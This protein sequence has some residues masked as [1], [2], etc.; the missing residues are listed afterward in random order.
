MRRSPTV[1]LPAEV[2]ERIGP[3]YGYVLVDPR[4][5]SIFYVGKGTGGRLLAHGDEALLRIGSGGQS[6]KVAR[7]RDGGCTGW[8]RYPGAD[9]SE[10]GPFNGRMMA[11]A[12]SSGVA[13]SAS[14]R[15]M[16]SLSSSSL[17]W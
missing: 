6:S 14:S 11:L 16:G 15:T 3:Y 9:Y 12:T 17:G 5:D 8:C 10:D 13:F 1:P 7:I 4:N 2:A